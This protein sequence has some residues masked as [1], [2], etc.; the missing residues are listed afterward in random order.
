MTSGRKGSSYDPRLDTLI[1]LARWRRLASIGTPVNDIAAAV[2]L[3]RAALD[4]MV[5]RARKHGLPDAIRHPNAAAAPGTGLRHVID[6]R[7]Y[8]HR[9]LAAQRRTGAAS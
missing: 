2:G 5:C 6:S 7:A 3:T 9:R 4:Q 1:R 8:H